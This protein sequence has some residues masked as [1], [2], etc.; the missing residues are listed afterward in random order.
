MYGKDIWIGDDSKVAI[1][2][3]R[4]VLGPMG[5]NISEAHNGLEAYQRL[6]HGKEQGRDI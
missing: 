5:L 2:Q 3:M 4:Q 1:E 6:M